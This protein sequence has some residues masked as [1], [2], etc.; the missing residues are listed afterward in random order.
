[1]VFLLAVL[2]IK[3][4]EDLR[5]LPDFRGRLLRWLQPR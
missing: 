1:M 5:S 2:I 4:F 3:H